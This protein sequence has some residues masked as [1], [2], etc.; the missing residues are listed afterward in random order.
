MEYHLILMLVN[1]HHLIN[2][3]YRFVFEVFLVHLVERIPRR[4]CCCCCSCLLSLVLYHVLEERRC[5]VRRMES[6]SQHFHISSCRV[7]QYKIDMV[8]RCHLCHSEDSVNR[9]A[10]S[11]VQVSDI[12]VHRQTAS[13]HDQ[14]GD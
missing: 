10:Y 8:E 3:H 13:Q 12:E 5:F 9:H 1:L 11:K 4:H 14:V 6:I 2:L 7:Q